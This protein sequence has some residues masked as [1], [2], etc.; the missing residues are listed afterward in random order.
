MSPF[1]SLPLKWCFKGHCIWRSSEEPQ[2]HDGNWGS[3]SKFGS[4]SRTCGGGVRS[5]SRQ[6]NNPP[7]VLRQQ[8]KFLQPNSLCGLC[9]CL[10]CNTVNV[11]KQNWIAVPGSASVL[12]LNIF[13]WPS[14]A[15]E[16]KSGTY[17]MYLCYSVYSLALHYDIWSIYLDVDGYLLVEF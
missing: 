2:G 13:M 12:A 7:W 11:R 16:F 1:M 3:W 15:I 8:G 17:C 6:C 9:V 10:W 5:R 4:C 14:V